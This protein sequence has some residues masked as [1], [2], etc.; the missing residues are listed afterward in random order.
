[1]VEKVVRELVR[2]YEIKNNMAFSDT[3]YEVV[4]YVCGLACSDKSRYDPN[5]VCKPHVDWLY[6]DPNGPEYP[7]QLIRAFAIVMYLNDVEEGGETYF[8]RQKVAITPKKGRI[9][10]Y[11]P[12]PTHPHEVFRNLDNF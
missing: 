12:T 4:K 2:E 3:G 5:E 6:T 8:S 10:V 11:P 9:V 7:L 1:M